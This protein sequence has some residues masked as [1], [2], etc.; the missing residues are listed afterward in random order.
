M[1]W[2]FHALI[3]TAIWLTNVEGRAWMSND[4]TLFSVDV[5][6]YPRPN[7]DAGLVYLY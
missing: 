5:I 4:N 7:S 1:W 2:L 6:T 3:V